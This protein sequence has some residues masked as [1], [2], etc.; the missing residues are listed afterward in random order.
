M[1][2]IAFSWKPGLHPSLIVAANRDEYF[3]RAS[4]EAHFWE[5]KKH[6]YGGQ[7]L[8]MGGTWLACSTSK[9]FAAVTNY[10][11]RE[12][13]GKAFP[14]SRGEIIINFIDTDKSA[15]E[16]CRELEPHK[17]DYRGFSIIL[18]DGTCLVCCSNRDP[19]NFVKE[20]SAGDYGLSNHLLDS[21][22][23][24]V[25]KAKKSLAKLTPDMT[26]EQIATVLL[27]ALAYKALA[28]EDAVLPMT[29]GAE[30]EK[31]RS[32]VFVQGPDFGTRTSTVV[33]FDDRYGFEVTEENHA[34]PSAIASIK[35][36]RISFGN[37]KA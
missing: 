20:L 21:P 9:R 1:C 31:I 29:L 26:H 33:T 25:V 30:E 7:D 5:E 27:E 6:I 13:I 18:F 8:R 37:N 32:A 23:P 35:Y 14:K 4:K 28:D 17:E 3:E 15:M 12:E 34:T 11:C 22:W 10:H 19:N 2:L 36:Q 16:F 24:K